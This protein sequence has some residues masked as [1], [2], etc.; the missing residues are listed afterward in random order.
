MQV[1]L[2]PATAALVARPC[3]RA[4]VVVVVVALLALA[5]RVAIPEA[6]LQQHRAEAA[7]QVLMAQRVLRCF[8]V[9]A[10]AEAPA[11]RLEAKAERPVAAA[12]ARVD[13]TPRRS[14]AA[15][16]VMEKCGWCH[17]RTL[18]DGPERDRG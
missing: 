16:V 9:R 8:V 3:S 5:A 14:W 10:A 1:T 2:R 7:Q 6:R 13:T 18:G 17:G 11:T 12:A 4:V 15:L